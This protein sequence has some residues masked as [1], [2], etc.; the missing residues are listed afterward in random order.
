MSDIKIQKKIEKK[1]RKNNFNRINI[2]VEKNIVKFSGEV[3]SYQDFIKIGYIAGKIKNVNGVVNNLHYPGYKEPLRSKGLNKKIANSDIIIIGGGVTGC[4]IARELSRYNVKTIVLEKQ[5]DVSCGATKANN[6]MVHSGIGETPGT[7]K[8]VLCVKGH[9]MFEKKAKELNVDYKKCGMFIILTKDSFTKTKIPNFLGRFI[10]RYIIPGIIIRR[11][12]KMGIPIEK[13][14]KEKLWELEP[15]TTKDA[16]IAVSSPTYGVTSP[17]EYTIA[18]AEN[19]I[20][21]GV[22]FSLNTEVVDIKKKSDNKFKVQTNKGFFETK[23]IINAAGVYA[24]KI[25]EMVDDRTYTI[26][27]RKGS[28]LLF[29]KEYAKS[30]THILKIL[31][32]PRKKH[33]KGGGIM[34]TTHGNIQ[35]GPTAIEI[36]DKKDKSVTVEE[37]NHIYQTYS[38]LIPD[39]PKKSIITFFSGIRAPTF[40]EDFIIKPSKKNKGFIHVAGIQSPGLAATPA[41]ADMVIEILKNQNIEL[42]EKPDF[43]PIR[44]KPIILNELSIDERNALIRKNPL[45]GHIICRCE[46]ISE[47]EIIDAINSPLPALNLDAIKRRTRAGM[48]RCQAGFCLPRVAEIIARETNIPI[49]KIVKNNPDSNLFVGKAKC[50]IECDIDE[51]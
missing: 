38:S 10:A 22:K 4:S 25:A 20:H 26:H 40:T 42:I 1:L 36:P 33:T 8:Q 46:H 17:Y 2:T 3:D 51:N 45:Y 27:P 9:F 23:F 35:W 29:D 28:T 13:V 24:D 39:F 11:G 41:I 47:G 12:R 32:F 50:L 21:N 49:E 15:K 48:G 6:A 34:L 37:I 7:L 44:H 43:N 18:L 19:A 31:S 5:E 16:L 30:F 14:K